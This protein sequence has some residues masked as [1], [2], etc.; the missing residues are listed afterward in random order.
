MSAPT[1]GLGGGALVG[2]VLHNATKVLFKRSKCLLYKF[3]W[4]CNTSVSDFPF[5]YSIFGAKSAVGIP[6]CSDIWFSLHF[7]STS[8]SSV[9]FMFRHILYQPKVWVDTQYH[10]LYVLIQVRKHSKHC[11]SCNKCVDGFDHHCRVIWNILYFFS[12]FFLFLLN[13]L[14]LPLNL[15]FIFWCSGWTI[16]SEEKTISHFCALWLWVLPGYVKISRMLQI[17]IVNMHIL[18]SVNKLVLS[19]YSKSVIF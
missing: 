5:I 9:Y 15:V 18:W 8:T 6:V 13:F 1:E 4:L 10:F 7:I 19:W 16:V 2:G 11:R 17:L 12:L 3:S 14:S